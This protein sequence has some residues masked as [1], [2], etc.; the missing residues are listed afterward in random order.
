MNGSG[1][2]FFFCPTPTPQ[3]PPSLLSCLLFWSA[4]AREWP[5]AIN[6]DQPKL[7]PLLQSDRV[8]SKR[9]GGGVRLAGRVMCAFVY[10]QQKGGRKEGGC[11]L[12]TGVK[13][14]ERKWME[15]R[16]ISC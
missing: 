16:K 1:W 13:G 12:G 9:A 7:L 4:V 6:V 3:L 14:R 10:Q 8:R 5:P 15:M 2:D 11:V